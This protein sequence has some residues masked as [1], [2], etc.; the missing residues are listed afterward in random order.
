M[1]HPK[2]QGAKGPT[3]NVDGHQPNTSKGRSF[4]RLQSPQVVD[5]LRDVGSGLL[6]RGCLVE[7]FS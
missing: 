5:E 4:P 1:K 7:I 3:P 2:H 6:E